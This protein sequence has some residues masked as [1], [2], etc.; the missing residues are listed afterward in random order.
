M[1]NTPNLD[2][3]MIEV[4]DNIKTTFLNKLNSNNTKIDNA[5][6]VLV[7]NLLENTN[8]DNLT[9]AIEEVN[10]SYIRIA[11]LEQELASTIASKDSIINE[12]NIEIT[13][14]NGIGD[15]NPTDIV[16][17][18]TALVQGQEVIG[19]YI[20]IP[21]INVTLSGSNSTYVGH[22]SGYWAGINQDGTLIISA[23]SSSASYE[24]IY[25]V[26]TSIDIG[27]ASSGFGINSFDTGDPASVPHS[28][29]VTGIDISQ[30]EEINVTLNVSGVNSTNDYISI[31]V[32]VS[33]I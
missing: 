31:Q 20:K 4:T 10:N 15:A 5:Y 21:K 27:T 14:L 32:T 19:E 22:I 29:I 1:S 12:L 9:D 25:F 17:G 28:C 3:E 18:K 24:H 30:Y 26:A 6:K 7:D 8:K 2:L 13:R 11:E 23:M 33:G 16:N